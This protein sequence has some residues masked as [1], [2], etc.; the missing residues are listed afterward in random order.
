[1]GSGPPDS[2]GS[3]VAMDLNN[4][5]SD[6]FGGVKAEPDNWMSGGVLM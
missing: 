2:A 1:M 5:N 3:F 4:M 6:Y